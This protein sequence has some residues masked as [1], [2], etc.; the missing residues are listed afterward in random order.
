MHIFYTPDISGTVYTLNEQESKHCV[1]VLRMQIGHSVL[2]VDGIGGL[3]EATI[4]AISKKQ[5][6]LQIQSHTKEYGKSAFNLHIAIAPTKNI[7][8]I[9]WFAEKA[10]EIGI[11]QISFLLCKRSERK[12]VKAERI[13]KVVTSAVKQ[14]VKAYHPVVTDIIPFAEF[15]QRFKDIDQ[16]YI[17]HCAPSNKTTL[18]EALEPGKDCV[19]LIGPE[20]DFS[21]EEI[22]LAL[23]Q[24]FRAIS[25]GKSRLRT[26]TAALA[27]CF[28][29]NYLNQ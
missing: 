10:T 6:V 15:I 22:K 17:A 9:E 13:E 27:A 24:G 8:R 25:L 29:A 4:S 1:Q 21:P 5:V 28:E 12:I 20:G 23:D 3:Y 14:S 19:I 18:K 16:K 26:E 2:L 11:H 7:E